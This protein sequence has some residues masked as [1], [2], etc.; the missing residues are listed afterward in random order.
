MLLIWLPETPLNVESGAEKDE[1]GSDDAGLDDAGSD[2]AGSDDAGSDE[3]GS[4]GL[5]V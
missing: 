5:L 2:D 1:V 3:V 4:R